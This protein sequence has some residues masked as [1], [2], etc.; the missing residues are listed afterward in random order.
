MRK[1][2]PKSHDGLTVN[3]LEIF[4]TMLFKYRRVKSQRIYTLF[5]QELQ[6]GLHQRQAIYQIM[7]T[8][9]PGIIHGHV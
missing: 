8:A 2:S 9:L 3:N 5:F 1:Y 4:S 7:G 6:I